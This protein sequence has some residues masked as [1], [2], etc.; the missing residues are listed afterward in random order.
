MI[1][2]SASRET[3]AAKAI[4]DSSKPFQGESTQVK[5]LTLARDAE[6]VFIQRGKGV[7]YI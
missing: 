2:E 6:S 4:S 5:F 1:I 7:E 3:V